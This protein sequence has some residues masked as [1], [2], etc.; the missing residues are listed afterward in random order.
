V[1]QGLRDMTVM[2]PTSAALVTRYTARGVDVTYRTY[3]DAA[4]GTVVADGGADATA[5]IATHLEGQRS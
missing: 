5:F 2:P 3:P 1:L 4:H